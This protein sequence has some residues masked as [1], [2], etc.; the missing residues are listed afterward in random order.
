VKFEIST[1]I[2]YWIINTM[3]SW[4]LLKNLENMSHLTILT[5]WKFRFS[6]FCC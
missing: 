3:H 1:D 4:G 2:F 6:R 5:M